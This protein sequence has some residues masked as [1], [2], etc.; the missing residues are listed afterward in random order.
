MK[1]QAHDILKL[2]DNLLASRGIPRIHAPSVAATNEQRLGNVRWLIDRM[3]M[4]QDDVEK[5]LAQDEVYLGRFVGFVQG[6]LYATQMMGLEAVQDQARSIR[7][8]VP[9]VTQ[10]A[11]Q[12][13]ANAGP[14]AK[15]PLLGGM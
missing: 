6:A 8:S 7:A 13:I 14:A 1:Q 9:A 10:E 4:P 5:A 15:S 11:V 12:E 3:L 2:A